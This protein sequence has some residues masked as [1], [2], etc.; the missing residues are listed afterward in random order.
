ML[1]SYVGL[2]IVPGC[3]ICGVV[4]AGTACIHYD[5][6]YNNYKTIT[7][8]AVS[9]TH[10]FIHAQRQGWKKCNISLEQDKNFLPVSQHF[11]CVFL[12]FIPSQVAK[13]PG[14]M[15]PKFPTFS[16]H[17]QRIVIYGVV[18]VSR[19]DQSK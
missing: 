9:Y 18:I 13:F 19:K 7:T 5:T 14:N 16:R 1:L 11:L 2:V 4:D 15:A 10:R 8:R 17:A 3:H 12:C 6:K